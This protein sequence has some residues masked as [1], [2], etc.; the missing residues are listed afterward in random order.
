ML[1]SIIEVRDFI[2]E[3]VQIIKHVDPNSK[4]WPK[5]LR[6]KLK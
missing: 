5:H 4:G 1:L 3:E 6:R 2:G